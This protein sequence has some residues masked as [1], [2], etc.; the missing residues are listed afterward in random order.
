M[1]YPPPVAAGP[2]PGAAPHPGAPFARPE[3]PAQVLDR[4]DPFAAGDHYGPVLEPILVKIVD[5]SVKVNPLISPLTDDGPERPYLKWDMLFET[6]TAVRSDEPPTLSWSNGRN[7]PATFPRLTSL[8]IISTMTPWMIVVKAK[9]LDRGVTCG[10]VIQA[11]WSDMSRLSTKQDFECL[12]PRD[13]AELG[14]AYKRNRSANPGVPGGSLGQGMRRLD[15]L[16]SCSMFGG[17]EANPNVVK[18]TCGAELPCVFV[19]R[20]GDRSL[21]LPQVQEQEARLRN[22]DAQRARSASRNAGARSRAN[23]VNTRISVHPPSSSSHSAY[24]NTSDSD[25]G[26]VD[27]GPRR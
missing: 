27:P 20:C 10:E 1:W 6:S 22:A 23:S 15:F 19:L 17:I 25:E 12:S 5:A 3:P 14:N 21:S 24:D 26:G 9:D 13:K 4:M 8:R 18:R 16:R 7:Q 11:I 2:H